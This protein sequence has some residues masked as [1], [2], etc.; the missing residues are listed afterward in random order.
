MF[1]ENGFDSPMPLYDSTKSGEQLV[2]VE[3]NTRVHANWVFS[4]PGAQTISVDVRGTDGKGTK[5]SYS[6]KLRF[7]VGDK[8]SANEARAIGSSPSA[9]TSVAPPASSRAAATEMS[10]G[11]SGDD[12]PWGPAIVAGVVI[13][14]IIVTALVGRS[15]SKKM[16]DEVWNEEGTGASETNKDSGDEPR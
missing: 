16:H 7:V 15:R 5:H 6:T 11:D 1:I 9:A 14:G 13:I 2:H 12:T 3:A 10:S 8:G 4:D